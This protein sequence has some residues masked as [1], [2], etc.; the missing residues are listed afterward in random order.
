MT[1]KN[2]FAPNGIPFLQLKKYAK[3]LQKLNSFTHQ[4]ALDQITKEKTNFN[5]WDDLNKYCNSK[6]K[7]IGKFKIKKQSIVI[8]GDKNC[9]WNNNTKMVGTG[10]T[11]SFSH[12]FLNKNKNVG[13]CDVRKILTEQNEITFANLNKLSDI[14]INLSFYTLNLD[15]KN[16]I[17]NLK[18]LEII[19]IMNVEFSNAKMLESIIIAAKKEGVIVVM[20]AESFSKPNKELL[21][22]ATKYCSIFFPIQEPL[23]NDLQSLHNSN[24]F[25]NMNLNI[26][27]VHGHKPT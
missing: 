12:V 2:K 13:I 27:I 10:N 9:I 3:K 26:P 5:T 23:K 25:S 24:V 1:I 15:H 19:Y 17:N 4:E 11:N 7:S 21:L 18:N 6:G 8:Y 14:E 16:I 20:V 22:L